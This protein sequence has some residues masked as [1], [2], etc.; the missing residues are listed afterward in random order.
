RLLL[1]WSLMGRR[2]GDGRRQ[3]RI[4]RGVFA[5]RLLGPID[6]LKETRLKTGADMIT[7]A[8]RGYQ[9][10]HAGRWRRAHPACD[11][12]LFEDLSRYRTLTD[13]PRRESSRLMLWAHGAMPGEVRMQGELYGVAVA[14]T[15]AAFSSR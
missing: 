15:G 8:A 14:D 6:A 12:V 7:Q 10:D 4:A 2:G 13:R 5:S 1:R 11:L 9:R 3:D